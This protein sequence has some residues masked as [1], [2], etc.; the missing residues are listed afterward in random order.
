MTY[1]E[2]FCSDETYRRASWVNVGY[3][4]FHELTGINIIITYSNVILQNI[5]GDSSS[6]FNARTGTYYIAIALFASSFVSI[7]IV[8][9]FGR[10][11][12]LLYGHFGIGIAYLLVSVFTINDMNYGVLLMLCFFIFVYMNTS[13]PVAWLYAAETCCDVSLSVCL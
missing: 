11:T 8:R 4:I 1:T 12:L 9:A 10:R 13:G 5:L 6:G 3:I 7:W 2:A